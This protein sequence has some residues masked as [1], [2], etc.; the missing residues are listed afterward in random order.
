M[1]AASIAGQ[2]RDD[3]SHPGPMP[4]LAEPMWAIPAMS[5]SAVAAEEAGADEAKMPASDAAWAIS[6][7]QPAAATAGTHRAGP[8]RT[9]ERSHERHASG[10]RVGRMTVVRRFS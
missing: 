4:G 5:C 8:G 9:S 1:V 10:A 3:A 6:T 7:T 2:I